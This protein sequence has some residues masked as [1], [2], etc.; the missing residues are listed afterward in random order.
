MSASSLSCPVLDRMEAR[1]RRLTT[2]RDGRRMVWRLWG[3]GPPLV[4]LHGGY[5]SWRHWIRTIPALEAQRTLLVA[6]LPGLG[7]SDDAS[8][9][10]T[11][12][13]IA[14]AVLH[15][16]DAILAPDEPRDVVG[17]S[18]GALI[19]GHIAALP[20]SGLC[21]LTLVGAGALGVPRADIRLEREAPGM[22][23][24]ARDAVHRSNLARLMIA[25]P[26][27]IDDLA[28]LIQRENVRR[29]RVKSR[30]FATG[31]SL[32]RA[33]RA[34]APRRLAAVWGERDAV[35]GAHLDARL[36]WFRDARPDARL[37]VVPEAG[38][39]VAYEAAGAFNA[40][41]LDLLR[42]G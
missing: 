7:D 3:A 38:H 2:E 32:A 15:G 41:L 10:A 16:L 12:E 40:V 8:E 39:W 18:F 23:G 34:G 42:P 30:R 22:T 5:G 19:G 29:A 26:A 24:A 11:P 36:A 37:R 21:S 28:V 25:D 13:S 31:D 14:H 20:G 17:F 4:L 35:V 9:P 6:D 33:L 27:R 1:A